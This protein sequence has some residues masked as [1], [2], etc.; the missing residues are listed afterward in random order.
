MCGIAGYVDNKIEDIQ[1]DSKVQLM[2]KQIQHRGPDDSGVIVSNGVGLGNVRLSITDLLGGK[3]PFTFGCADS[4]LVLV[5]NGEIYN[6]IDLKRD[7]KSLGHE[8]HSSHSDTEVVLHAFEEWGVSS[9]D[10]LNGMFAIVILDRASN[11]IYLARDRFGEKPLYL[12]SGSGVFAFASEIKCLVEACNLRGNFDWQVIDMYINFGYKISNKSFFVGV[13]EVPAGS[14]TIVDINKKEVT[15]NLIFEEFLPFKPKALVPPSVSNESTF[16]QLFFEAVQQR[17]NADAKTGV[18]LSGGL[19]SSAVALAASKVSSE[20]DTFTIG[21]ENPRFDESAHAIVVSNHLGLANHMEICKESDLMRITRRLPEIFDEPIADPSVIPTTFLS[22]FASGWVKVALGG[23][24]S[25]ELMFGYNTYNALWKVTK[26]KKAL[27]FFNSFDTGS[28]EKFFPENLQKNLSYQKKISLYSDVEKVFILLS[29]NKFSNLWNSE[30]VRKELH[31]ATSKI[32]LDVDQMKTF[33]NAYIAGYLEKNILVK[34]DRS[35]MSSSVE[36]RSPFLD[37]ALSQWTLNLDTNS[38][39][40]FGSGKRLL[41]AM[42]HKELPAQILKRPKQG[43]GAPMDDWFRGEL[44]EYAK[45]LFED[46]NASANLLVK[47]YRLKDLLSR[48]RENQVQ[49]GNQLWAMLVL[50]QWI[51]YWS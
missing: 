40:R 28:L 8:F 16:Q 15:K 37:Y 3:Q 11:L 26:L 18:F 33:R 19:D 51:N 13:E 2:L 35:T 23:D 44:G 14:F 46:G 7:L 24:G 41:R 50:C 47:K 43:F 38:H 9:F 12:F 10:R 39:F 22:E 17:L 4:D 25:D 29:P 20:I 32:Q 21:F 1:V 27:S 36:L 31:S 49:A 6:H 45:E 34:A 5:F 42:L 48:H 30:D